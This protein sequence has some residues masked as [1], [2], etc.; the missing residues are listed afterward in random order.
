V[1]D[2]VVGPDSFVAVFG[3]AMGSYAGKRCT[4]AWPLALFTTTVTVSN[5]N[6]RLSQPRN[7]REEKSRHA[8]RF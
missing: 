2:A 4:S 1:E 5:L 6:S 3:I 7:N 8:E